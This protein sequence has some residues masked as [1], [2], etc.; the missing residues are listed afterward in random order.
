MPKEQGEQ[1]GAAWLTHAPRDTYRTMGDPPQATQT[2]T[3]TAAATA[4]E[5]TEETSARRSVRLKLK[6]LMCM[7]TAKACAY[8]YGESFPELY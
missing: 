2:A 4:D 1:S 3:E 8:K 5:N 6:R 7:Y